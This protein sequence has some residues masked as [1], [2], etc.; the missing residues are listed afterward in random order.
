MP[1][2]CTEDPGMREND[3]KAIVKRVESVLDK[4]YEQR[5]DKSDKR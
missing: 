2:Y 1:R 5:V 3:M 4:T